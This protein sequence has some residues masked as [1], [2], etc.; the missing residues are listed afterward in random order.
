MSRAKITKIE[1]SKFNSEYYKNKYESFICKLNKE[2][3]KRL[4]KILEENNI[5]FTEFVKTSIEL[6]EGKKIKVEK[7]LE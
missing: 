5:G 1:P 2:D 4:K 3:T 7:R 6:I